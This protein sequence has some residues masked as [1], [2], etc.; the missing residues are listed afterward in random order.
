M[1]SLCQYVSE[2]I[3]NI[4]EIFIFMFTSI[5]L[6]AA[7][8]GTGIGILYGVASGTCKKTMYPY[9]QSLT[10]TADM[11]DFI[12]LAFPQVVNNW[13]LILTFAE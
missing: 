11:F 1:P 7:V 13:F 5:F 8:L 3:A 12:V 9:Q 6:L 4:V 2:L 10:F